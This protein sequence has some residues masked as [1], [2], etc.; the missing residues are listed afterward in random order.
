MGFIKTVL[1]TI[2]YKRVVNEIKNQND[3]ILNG[4]SNLTT[5]DASIINNSIVPQF[6]QADSDVINMLNRLKEQ[7]GVVVNTMETFESKVEEVNQ[8]STAAGSQLA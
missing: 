8:D 2:E 1:D 7:I 5:A 3:E 4:F 6:V